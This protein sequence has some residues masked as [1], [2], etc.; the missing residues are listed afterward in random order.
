MEIKFDLKL[1][2][3]YKAK[4]LSELPSVIGKTKQI[5]FPGATERGGQNGLFVEIIP[6]SDIPWIGIFA[7]GYGSPNVFTGVFSCPDK[8][9]ICVVSAGAGYLVRTDKPDIWSKISCFPILDACSILERQMLVFADYTSMEAISTEGIAW[10]I[11]S[12]VW[13]GIKITECT[14]DYV[15]GM[16]WDVSQ[17]SNVKYEVNIGKDVLEVQPTTLEIF[18]KPLGTTSL[19][20][21]NRFGDRVVLDPLIIQ[22]EN[23]FTQ[24]S[25]IKLLTRIKHLKQERNRLHKI[26]YSHPKE[27]RSD[28]PEWEQFDIVAK[29]IRVLAQEYVNRLPIYQLAQCPYCHTRLLQ[30][31]DSFSLMGFSSVLNV[32]KLYEGSNEWHTIPSPRQKC[33]HAL[34]A[35]VFVNLNTLKPD[36]LSPLISDSYLAV[37]DSSPYVI[38]WP[39]I[40]RFTSAVIHTL[41]I[42]RLDEP[43]PTHSYTAYI[44]TYFADD[45]SNIDSMWVSGGMKSGYAV[46]ATGNVQIDF[47]LEKW[48]DSDRILWLNPNNTNELLQTPKEVFPY[49]NIQ[50]Q[51][52]YRII[53]NG[54]VEGPHPFNPRFTWQRDAPYHNESFPQTIE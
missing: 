46:P 47:E 51:G 52:R 42:G 41:P 34:F 9:S 14:N 28:L 20:T 12:S 10:S 8:H 24:E 18:Y 39:L 30:P 5:Y 54:E 25:Y 49:A 32:K 26:I 37:F 50:P 38:V 36:D 23:V 3:Q 2:H 1:P 22:P 27:D 11:N 13:D 48:L 44:V 17:Q 6:D 45:N 7:F 21:T 35:S 15:K 53:E 4:I 29:Q 31:F 19:P 16:A 40:A 43:I 33:R